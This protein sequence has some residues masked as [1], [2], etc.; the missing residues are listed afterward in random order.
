MREKSMAVRFT[1]A[2]LGLLISWAGGPMLTAE[3]DAPVVE[4][5]FE[6]LTQGY[7]SL[8]AKIKK[9]EEQ[10]ADGGRPVAKASDDDGAASLQEFLKII[11]SLG[12]IRTEECSEFLASK[13]EEQANLGIVGAL[14]RALGRHGN[15][16]ALKAIILTGIPK[17]LQKKQDTGDFDLFTGL[18]SYSFEEAFQHKFDADAE[19]WLL[20]K[21]LTPVVRGH[22]GAYAVVLKKICRLESADKGKVLKAELKKARAD[23]SLVALLEV[24]RSEKPEGVSKS[25]VRLLKNRKVAVRLAAAEALLGL[26]IKNKSTSKKYIRLLKDRDWRVQVVAVDALSMCGDTAVIKKLVPLLK[27]KKNN[28]R[29]AVV[30]ALALF[31]TEEVIDPLI[32]ALDESEG[33]VKDDIADALARLTGVDMGPSGAQWESW[34]ASK[35]DTVKIRRRTMEEFIALKGAT[36]EEQANRRTLLY[37]GLRVLSDKLVFIID[38]SESMEEEFSR[39]KSSKSKSKSTTK[40]AGTEKND[41]E[42]V[43][44]IVAARQE[45]HKV[46]KGLRNGVS[47]NVLRFNTLI[48][49]W[50]GVIESLN[51]TLRRDLRKFIDDSVPVGQTNIYGAIEM[52]FE[53]PKVDTI[54]L[55]SDGA[56]TAGKYVKP[57]EVL[58]GVRDL[59][60]LRKL[61]IN[62]IGINI[63]EESTRDL[64]QKLADENF[65]VFVAR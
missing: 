38:C 63:Q 35:K 10:Q 34:W 33:R 15:Q 64:L 42:L 48:R 58:A 27:A 55:L 3:E 6:E 45:L 13:I 18:G 44:K 46:V 60:R 16:T 4:K 32:A 41:E 20:K 61:K 28:V 1:A 36:D 47:I 19:K 56:P 8:A 23:E 50:R 29:I 52:T 54:Y 2:F 22:P 17:F 31:A 40:V 65:G 51:D 30:A 21:G 37:H 59:N 14:V 7:E 5:S 9:S 49:P 39:Q 24:F 26:G 57:E 12:L 43:P 53:D 62:T 25:I 11:D